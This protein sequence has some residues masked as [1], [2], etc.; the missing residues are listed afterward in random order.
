VAQEA[1]GARE[2]PKVTCRE[3]LSASALDIQQSLF[4]VTMKAQARSCMLPP[5]DKNPFIRL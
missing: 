2:L 1:H 4:K 5:F 3:L